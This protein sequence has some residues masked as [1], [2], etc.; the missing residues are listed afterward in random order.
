MRR[1]IATFAIALAWLLAN[2]GAWDVLQV[3]A[4]GKMFAGY[5][6]TM[7]LAAALSAT[8]DPTRPCELCVGIAEAKDEA[9]ETAPASEQQRSAKFVSVIQEV[10]GPLFLEVSETWLA[11]PTMKLAERTD[12]VPV[13]PPRV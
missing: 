11:T 10:D 2:G 8:L 12:P 3:A 1:R 5:A 6:E 9:N 4:W 13:P 7:P